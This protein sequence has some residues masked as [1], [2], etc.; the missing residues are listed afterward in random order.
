MNYRRAGAALAAVL[1][2][3]HLFAEELLPPSQPLMPY[4]ESSATAATKAALDL[5][6]TFDKRDLD[7]F[8]FDLDAAER[9]DWSNLPARSLPRPGIPVGDMTDEQRA[10]LYTFLA[11]ALGEYG[12]EV[13]RQVMAAEAF[14][15]QDT[16]RAAFLKWSPRN[17]WIAFYGVP[18]F[19]SPWGW[20]FGGHHLGLNLT[21]Q[22]D[23]V[24]SMSPTF[25]GTEPSVFSLDDADYEVVRDM[26]LA[27]Y[28]LYQAL[29]PEQQEVADAGSVPEE[30]LTG[31][32]N[33]GVIPPV[34][35]LSA[36][37][38]T[39]AQ[40][41]LLV[42]AIELWVSVQP[43][44][45]ASRR[46]AE[47]RDELGS[48][49][50]AWTGGDKVNTPTYM[51]IQG[52]SLIIELLSTGGNVGGNAVGQGHYHTIYRNPMMEYGAER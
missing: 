16:V 47:I 35:G 40:L 4:G 12:Y 13:V 33:D 15:S 43:A 49:H 27:G 6:V 52:P 7:D 19:S 10:A 25:I 1:I 50:F 11:S 23:R 37:E 8:I 41:D 39:L 51:V 5:M 36:S 2:S 17:Y 38:M 22:G 34:I 3:A 28:A 45:D 42:A 48:V 26:H 14:L 18:N 32:G 46:M 44:E 9:A 21:L 30:V 29:E 31:A 24:V 20:G